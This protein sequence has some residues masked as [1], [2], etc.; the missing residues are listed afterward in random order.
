[1][2]ALLAVGLHSNDVT[3]AATGMAAVAGHVYP[4]WL[5]F[6]GGKG[7]ATA[8]GVFSVLTPVATAIA[9]ATFVGVVWFSR[10]VSM[11]SIVASL[12]LP[13]VAYL[14]EAPQPFVI[15]SIGG[16]ALILYRHWGNVVRLCAG[17]ERR[18]GQQV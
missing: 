6:Q 18:L 1:M 3:V 16:S 10:Y 9:V 17:T 8:C 12:L 13:V 5:K 4:L 11:G 7:V 15:C 2:T 14:S